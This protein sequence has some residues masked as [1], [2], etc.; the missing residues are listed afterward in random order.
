[1]LP[2]GDKDLIDAMKNLYKTLHKGCIGSG[3]NRIPING[4]TTLLPRAKGLTPLER[5]LALAH[6]LMARDM[7]GTQQLRQLMG[8]TQFGARVSYGDCL[9]LTLSPNPQMSA[10]TL[11]LSRYRDDDPYVQHGSAQTRALAGGDAPL[12]EG[13]RDAVDVDIPI[14]DDRLTATARDPL[15][16]IE[17]YRVEIYLRL[18]A[19]LGVRMCPHCPRCNDSI[20]GC[21]DLLGSNMRPMG[22]VLGGMPALGGATE[23]QGHGTPHLHLEGHVVCIY[24][25]GTLEEIASKIQT[26]GFGHL[27]VDNFHAYNDWL[28]RTDVLD[29]AVYDEFRGKVEAAFDTRFAGSS[30]DPLCVTPAFVYEDAMAGGAQTHGEGHETWTT[31]VQSLI[32]GLEYRRLYLRHAQFVFSRVQHH[33]HQCT[34]KGYVPLHNCARKGRKGRKAGA[35]DTCKA[36][37]PMANL[38]SK[39]SVLVCRGVAK[40]LKL[41]TSGRRNALG[42]IIGRRTCEWQSGTTPSFAVLF[43][44]NSHTAPNYRLPV[45]QQTHDDERCESLACKAWMAEKGSTK[46][47]AKLA[48]RAQR[49]ATGYYCGY[50]FKRQPVG[51]KYLHSMAQTLGDMVEGFAN[52]TAAQRWHRLTHRIMQDFQGRAMVRTA[53]EEW[54]LASR[55]HDQ[56]PTT[57]EFV[58]TYMSQDLPG[59]QLVLRLEMEEKNL[60]GRDVRKVVPRRHGVRSGPDDRLRHFVDFYGYRGTHPGVFYLSPWEFLTLWEVLPLPTPAATAGDAAK[61]L[62]RWVPRPKKRKPADEEEAAEYEPNTA[63]ALASED[64]HASIVF[65]GTIPGDVQLRNR[66]YMRRRLRPMVP[67]LSD[68]PMPDK[69]QDKDKKARLFALYLRPWVLDPA[70]ARPTAFVVHLGDL[71]RV[72]PTNE[73]SYSRAW[74][75]YVRGHVVSRHARRIIVQFMAAC[76]G[77]STQRES[78]ELAIA[79]EAMAVPDNAVPLDRVRAL[80]SGLAVKASQ[81][82]GAGRKA[83]AADDEAAGESEDDAE[84][85]HRKAVGRSQQIQN[86]LTITNER[87]AEGSGLPAD[88]DWCCFFCVGFALVWTI[89]CRGVVLVFALALYWY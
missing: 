68:A 88:P 65:Y 38:R 33:V 16:I 66:W 69:Q 70:H 49:E 37:F 35:G 36:D 59:I 78:L 25:Y 62:S 47:I 81:D 72:Y 14:Y 13:K 79:R 85:A 23:H 5:R 74:S 20:N 63:L 30:H 54:N 11:R 51:T 73:R 46:K 80:L 75:A 8:H 17:A 9:F 1:M 31:D 3:V 18:A 64:K 10:L 45:M 61:A 21:Q 83:N 28:H 71:D 57:A 76:C 42:K 58:R 44:S 7:S 6:S 43:G 48:Q 32:D 60:S 39:K 41:K 29:Q 55:W 24:Q 56:D 84:H 19:L 52:K 89:V 12:L 40:K 22:G 2:W 82:D 67:A 87:R 34:K 50:N 53:P 4:D 77:K 26:D 86:A 15:A 27:S